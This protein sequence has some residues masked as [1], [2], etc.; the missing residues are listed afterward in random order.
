MKLLIADDE[1]VIRNGL[2]SLD[3]EKIGITEVYSARNG[4]EAKEL[5]LSEPIDIVIFDIRMPG[6]T[7]LELAAM[8]KEYSM[9]TAVILLTGFSEFSYAQEALRS[10]VSDYLLKPFHPR[11]IIKTVETVKKNLEKERYLTRLAREYED[12]KGSFDT[13]SQVKNIFPKVSQSVENILEDIAREFDQPLSLGTFAERYH[14]SNNYISKKIKQE[15]GYSFMDILL[16]VRVMNAAK[17]LYEGEKVNKTAQQ[18]GF[19]DQHY[20]SQ[21]FRRAFGCSPTDF[22]KQETDMQNIKLIPVLNSMSE[23][24]GQ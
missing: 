16:A 20:F 17:L 1:L 15:T 5:L 8:V 9:D 24:S 13:M 19:N 22:K 2:V 23:R 11:D 12:T 3:W 10:G 6:M 14:F 7:G 4:M 21:V 18:T